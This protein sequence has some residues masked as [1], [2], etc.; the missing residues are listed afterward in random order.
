MIKAQ[1]IGQW[2]LMTLSL[3]LVAVAIVIDMCTAMYTISKR[4]LTKK[5]HVRVTAPAEKA[6]SKE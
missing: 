1:K 4:K 2:V 3:P 6:E 5:K